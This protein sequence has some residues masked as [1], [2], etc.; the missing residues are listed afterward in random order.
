MSFI[1][2]LRNKFFFYIISSQRSPANS[3]IEKFRELKYL[4]DIL[5][6]LN[7][8]TVIDVGANEGQFAIDLRR[9]GY[10]GKIIS[11]EP[12]SRPYE[13]LKQKAS[14]DAGWSCFQLALGA[15]DGMA[16]LNAA[17]DSKLSSLLTSDVL[18]NEFFETE[19]VT[20]CR[21][22][23]F[24]LARGIINDEKSVFLKIDTQGFDLEVFAGSKDLLSKISGIMTEVSVKPLY[25]NMVNYKEAITVYEEAGYSLAGL[26]VVA[27]NNNR[28]IVEFNCF[29]KKE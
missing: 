15:K 4:K 22:D 7:I 17:K 5:T 1:R 13:I 23:E 27:V 3:L 21:L 19:E 26:S 18:H 20:V 14:G 29:F 10:M 9:I 11:F 25:N 28:N 16:V 24:L 8:T 12:G 2:K 6:D